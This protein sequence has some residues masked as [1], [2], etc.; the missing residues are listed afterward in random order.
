M[1]DG[2]VSSVGSSQGECTHELRAE[3]G[4]T[5]RDDSRHLR[6]FIPFPLGM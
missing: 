4:G 5:L 6:C 1:N 3:A 2:A